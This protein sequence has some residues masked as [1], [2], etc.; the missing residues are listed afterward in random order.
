VDTVVTEE[1]LVRDQ[2]S[3]AR[4]IGLEPQAL[5]RQ[6]VAQDLDLLGRVQ[7]FLPEHDRSGRYQPRI[8]ED[9]L[10]ERVL[11][12]YRRLWHDKETA[13]VRDLYFHGATLAGP[14]GETAYG[15]G[16]IDR[17]YLGYLAS[18]PDAALSVHS[19]ILNRDSDQPPRIALR[20]SLRG[21][22]SGFGHFGPP[23]G[24]D[25]YIMGMSHIS[26]VDG[27]IRQEF[28]V[29]DEVS[30]WKQ[31]IAHQHSKAGS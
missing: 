10:V 3:F 4:C 31:I 28:V 8:A 24:A 12:S 1:W 19:A 23:T 16:D 5:A 17:F 29:T 22:H 6:M 13:A 26:L 15:H 7:F 27:L 9:A 21:R 30:I 11:V 20:W 25:V 18:F 14:G 2:A